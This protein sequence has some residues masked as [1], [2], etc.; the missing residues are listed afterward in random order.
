MDSINMRVLLALGFPVIT[1]PLCLDR[2]G[3]G[4]V[5]FFKFIPAHHASKSPLLIFF[6][7]SVLDAQDLRYSDGTLI[8]KGNMDLEALH[9]DDALYGNPEEFPFT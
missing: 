9:Y 6:F 7:P 2:L 5:F 4:R 8:P 1:V 3:R